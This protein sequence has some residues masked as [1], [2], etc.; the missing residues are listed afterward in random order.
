MKKAAIVG[1]GNIAGFLD[2]PESNTIVTHAHAYKIH[3]DTQLI[4]C[5]DPDS[6]Q[7]TKFCSRWGDDIHA[8]TSLHVLL[9]NETINIL[10]ICSPTESHAHDLKL[11]LQNPSI[12]T[13][14]CEKPFIQTQN[15]LDELLPLLKQTKKKNIINFII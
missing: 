1:C 10:S 15:E 14:I 6:I 5:C 13:I 9:E 8:Y 4:A 2:S 7:N 11:A 12:T 3:T